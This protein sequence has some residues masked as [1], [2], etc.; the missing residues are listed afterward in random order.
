MDLLLI[1]LAL[2]FVL[3]NAFFVAAE[4]AMVKLRESRV[5]SM[6]EN[7]GLSGR[8]L[9]RVHKNLET[10]LSA[11]QLGITL[12][13]LGLG[14][15]GEPAFAHILEPVLKFLNINSP[16]LIKIISFGAAFSI[17]SF[18]HIV[19]G[20]LM[21]KTMAIRQSE[22]LSLYTAMPLYLFY[23]L[24]YPFIW[25]LNYSANILLKLF[26]LDAVHH[27][28]QTYSADEVKF[29]LKSTHVHNELNPELNDKYR[30]ILIRMLE[31][32]GLEAVDVM[33]PL[34]E[35][36]G[37]SQDWTL[38][39]KLNIIKQYKY[40]RYPVYQ[41][42]MNN[43]IGLLHVKD[44]IVE[45]KEN[46]DAP[47]SLRPVVKTYRQ[48]KAIEILEQFQQGMP[49]FALVYHHNK[50][51]GFITLDNLLHVLIGKMRDEFNL[52]QEDW[53]QLPDGSYVIKGTSPV[54]IIEKLLSI[55]LSEYDIDTVAGL[56][57]NNL[58]HMPVEGEEWHHPAFTL[59]A[60]KVQGHRIVEVSLIPPKAKNYL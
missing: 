28:E 54:Y 27:G 39:E 2:G 22:R 47:I 41:N 46:P 51:I 32:T 16:E 9:F 29:I 43:I 52:T 23:W 31:F 1:L 11:C 55:D 50:P 18:L 6:K 40:T 58:G 21:P 33:R 57:F 13:S 45:D 59:R 60:Q 44:F 35:M 37:I 25:M 19:V 26:R 48:T 36:I 7:Y 15:V 34:E 17:I 30:D 4:F 42:N 10:Y 56:L 20:E 3:L 8:V 53:H 24:M 12:A 14:W 38:Q 49:H 5:Q